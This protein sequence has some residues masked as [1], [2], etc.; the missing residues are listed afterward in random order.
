M[1]KM[2]KIFKKN[3][4]RTDWLF[5]GNLKTVSF[6]IHKGADVNEMKSDG[7][8]PLHLAAQNGNLN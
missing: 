5:S 8:A 7:R 6:L 2:R 4:K 1:K 3:F